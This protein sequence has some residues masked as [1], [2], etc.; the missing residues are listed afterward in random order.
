M[1]HYERIVITRSMTKKIGDDYKKAEISK[2]IFFAPGECVYDMEG[3]FQVSHE[4]VIS[5]IISETD[6]ELAEIMSAPNT[7]GEFQPANQ[8]TETKD[9]SVGAFRSETKTWLHCPLCGNEAIGHV[10]G[11]GTP[12]QACFGCSTFLQPDGTTKPMRT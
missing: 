12:Y 4:E 3:R 9:W 5:K 10:S 6:N 7:T 1:A 8:L 11:K 2:E